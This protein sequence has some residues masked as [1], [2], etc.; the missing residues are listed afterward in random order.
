MYQHA[1]RGWLIGVACH[2]QK[3]AWQLSNPAGN[4]LQPAINMSASRYNG[5]Q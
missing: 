1:S 2:H 4:G 5:L 3:A